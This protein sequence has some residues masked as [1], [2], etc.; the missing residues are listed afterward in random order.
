MKYIAY[1]LI[2]S[3]TPL[4]DKR[5]RV[6]FRNGDIRIYDCRPLLDRSV[7]A[8]L[9]EEAFFRNVHVDSAGYGI[10]WNDQVDLS[11]AELWLN[12]VEEAVQK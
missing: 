9:K 5:L 10:I 12:G 8:P 7:F 3:V 11:E 6:E 2:K 4:P 1:P